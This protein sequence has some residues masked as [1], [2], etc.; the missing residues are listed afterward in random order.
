MI[1]R[2][3]DQ[4]IEK[5][6]KYENLTEHIPSNE[7]FCFLMENLNKL[8]DEYI[9]NVI[10][11]LL[12][13]YCRPLDSTNA[14]IYCN[15][16]YVS[17][18][19]NMGIAL[20]QSEYYHRLINNYEAWEGLTW[21]VQLIKYKPLEAIKALSLY[22]DAKISYMPDYRIVGINQC[23]DIIEGKFIKN[24]T[25]KQQILFTFKPREF[26]ILIYKL[27]LAMN[28][29]A[30]LTPATRDGG[31]DVIATRKRSDGVEKLYIEC[32]LYQTTELKKET[33]RAFGYEVLDNRSIN[34]GVMFTTVKVNNQLKD[35]HP[36]IN[37][38]ELD[39]VIVLLNSYL[40]YNWEDRID[41][42][43]NLK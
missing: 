9:L 33:V 19:L 40:G 42:L 18:F 32:K 4:W 26:E 1:K 15:P 13:S 6:F 3:F 39:E 38:L 8:T 24:L 30:E 28:C 20:P 25:G 2:D 23:I 11:C 31:K 7:M 29:E 10:R 21:I 17:A 35:L 12:H 16:E 22:M 41:I 34:R 5:L 37:V 36:R 43:K 14:A 27:Y